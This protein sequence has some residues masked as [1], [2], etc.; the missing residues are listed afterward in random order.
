[1]VEF[2][3]GFIVMAA[4]SSFTLGVFWANNEIN[5]NTIL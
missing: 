4:V 3:I 5:K 2:L 1:M